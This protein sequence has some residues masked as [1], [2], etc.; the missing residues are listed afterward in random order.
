MSWLPLCAS[1]RITRSAS[2]PSGTLS[3]YLVTTLSPSAFSISLRPESCWNVQPASLTG[4]TYTKPTL[5]GASAAAADPVHGTNPTTSTTSVACSV[6]H[7]QRLS[8]GDISLSLNEPLRSDVVRTGERAFYPRRL[9]LRMIGFAERCGRVE[10][11]RHRI[12]RDD[13]QH[14]DRREIGQHRQQLRG[15]G[16]THRLGLELGQRDGAEQV[17]AS[18][19]APWFPGREH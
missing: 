3:T 7:V 1:S 8:I 10:T 5:N 15:Q 19:H 2:A 14:D 9:R 16:D 17:G 6:Q 13:G 11:D 18:Q 4:P 12:A